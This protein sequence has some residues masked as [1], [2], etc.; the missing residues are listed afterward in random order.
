MG[1]CVLLPYTDSAV[2]EDSLSLLCILMLSC[3]G[4][5]VRLFKVEVPKRSWG[6]MRGAGVLFAGN[7]AFVMLL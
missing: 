4:V 1:W 3:L 2:L 5:E 6:R 7:T